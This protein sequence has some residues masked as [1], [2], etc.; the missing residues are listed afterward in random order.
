MYTLFTG[1]S[2]LG[3]L[4]ALLDA[5]FIVGYLLWLVWGYATQFG[6]FAPLNMREI[7]GFCAWM[8]AFMAIYVVAGAIAHN[9]KK[10]VKNG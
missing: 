4:L 9:Y 5:G 7:S 2:W 3:L 6:F 8:V 1:I 10:E